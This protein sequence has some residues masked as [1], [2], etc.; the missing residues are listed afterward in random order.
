M[1]NLLTW[2]VRGLANKP[3]MRRIEA[4]CK[5]HKVLI[6][7]IIEPTLPAK[8]VKQIQMQLGFSTAIK[9]IWIVA[10]KDT[11]LCFIDDFEQ[12]LSVRVGY[13]TL[14]QHPLLTVV[15]GSCSSG[16]GGLWDHLLGI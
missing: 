13:S 4:L 1:F 7:A 3:T 11:N 16:R 6:I 9:D 12:V 15:H 2:N 5:L 10:T 14:N 8:R